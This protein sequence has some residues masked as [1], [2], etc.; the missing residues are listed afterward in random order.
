M[1]KKQLAINK[2]HTACLHRVSHLLVANCFFL[3][4]LFLCACND[5]KSDND[6]GTSPF[7]YHTTTGNPHFDLPDIQENGELIILTLY[8]P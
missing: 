7:V 2:S 6:V 5:G 4:A 8:G 3:L 1:D